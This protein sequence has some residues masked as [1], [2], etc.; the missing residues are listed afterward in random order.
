MIKQYISNV[1]KS[2]EKGIVVPIIERVTTRTATKMVV[3]VDS[4]ICWRTRSRAKSVRLLIK[5]T[6]FFQEAIWNY[7]YERYRNDLTIGTKFLNVV[8]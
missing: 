5:F 4:D 7:S 8:S 2:A 1:M 6:V 3:R